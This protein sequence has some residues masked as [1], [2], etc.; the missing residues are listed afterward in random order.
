MHKEKAAKNVDKIYDEIL[1]KEK[2]KKQANKQRIYRRENEQRNDSKNEG[3]KQSHALWLNYYYYNLQGFFG[4]TENIQSR[5]CWMRIEHWHFNLFGVYVAAL[6]IT[7]GFQVNSI[8]SAHPWLYKTP[9]YT[10]ARSR[11]VFVT[12]TASVAGCQRRHIVQSK[13]EQRAMFSS[14][15]SLSIY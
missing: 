3:I 9:S 5:T 7:L 10:A 1:R 12:I 14:S 15:L 11:C 13:N 4:C 2:K 8:K 6:S